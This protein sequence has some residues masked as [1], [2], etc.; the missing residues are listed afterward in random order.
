MGFNRDANA[1]IGYSDELIYAYLAQGLTY[2]KQKLDD[3]EFLETSRVP[4]A[5]LLQLSLD[6]K[7]QDAKTIIALLWA[8]NFRQGNRSK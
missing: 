4:M 6:A 7:M 1:L 2:S 3:E 8:E 5:E